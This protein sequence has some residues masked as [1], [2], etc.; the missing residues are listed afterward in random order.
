MRWV[1]R[2]PTSSSVGSDDH[3]VP[4]PPSHPNRPG[5]AATPS[6]RVITDS[7]NPHPRLSQKPGTKPESAFCSV[8]AMTTD[9]LTTEQKALSGFRSEE[10]TSELQSHLNLVCRL[11]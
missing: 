3:E 10:H 1:I 11:L 9:Q 6:R 7:P 8:E 5:T 2:I 4:S